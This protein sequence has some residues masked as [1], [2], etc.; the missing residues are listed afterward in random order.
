M[1]AFSINYKNNVLISITDNIEN[2]KRKKQGENEITYS[3]SSFILKWIEY[4]DLHMIARENGAI[5]V[6]ETK[7][8]YIPFFRDDNILDRLFE[9][10]EYILLSQRYR[11][12]LFDHNVKIALPEMKL[13]F[14]DETII[15]EIN[16]PKQDYH[17]PNKDSFCFSVNAFGHFSTFNILN[18]KFYELLS[19]D[20]DVH[21]STAQIYE[22]SIEC[23]RYYLEI[24]L[25]KHLSDCCILSIYYDTCTETEEILSLIPSDLDIFSSSPSSILRKRLMSQINN[26]IIKN[27]YLV[28]SEKLFLYA[29]DCFFALNSTFEPDLMKKLLVNENAISELRDQIM[30]ELYSTDFVINKL[31]IKENTIEAI[32]IHRKNHN[33]EN[34]IIKYNGP[35]IISRNDSLLDS[36]YIENTFFYITLIYS[37][38]GNGTRNP[39]LYPCDNSEINIYHYIK[40]L[41]NDETF[42]TDYFPLK[43]EAKADELTVDTDSLIE[44]LVSA[45]TGIS[46]AD[47]ENNSI[48]RCMKCQKLILINTQKTLY[49]SKCAKENK[50]SVP[51]T[52]SAAI[53]R[54]YN[55][56]RRTIFE[57]ENNIKG[58]LY[59]TDQN[60][61]KLKGESIEK[62]IKDCFFCYLLHHFELMRNIIEEDYKSSILNGNEIQANEI[63]D[64]ALNFLLKKK[65]P[66]FQPPESFE[67]QIHTSSKKL[68]KK[69]FF[70][71]NWGDIFQYVVTPVEEVPENRESYSTI[72]KELI[73]SNILRINEIS[74]CIEPFD[75]PYFTIYKTNLL[76][77]VNQACKTH[78]SQSAKWR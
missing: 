76:P 23:K 72:I 16:I 7:E 35:F 41:I 5:T 48:R 49:C 29:K 39:L 6:S 46:E 44:V 65:H 24:F 11:N 71:F 61:Y 59:R 22:H 47:N 3:P 9:T 37:I 32:G 52:T 43:D 58:L 38:M 31:Y 4:T 67:Y 19:E 12:E 50:N 40:N 42:F 2:K 78:P 75:S 74:D 66:L 55:N 57:D 15:D 53:K 34:R 27:N 68:L 64:Y 36:P 17:Y 63:E 62:V 33:P 25:K 45:L 13:I 54:G 21:F 60:R 56:L 18:A 26:T 73:L 8:T 14:N 1:K 10:N 20:E 69:Y 28:F 51:K 30:D 77:I 70:A